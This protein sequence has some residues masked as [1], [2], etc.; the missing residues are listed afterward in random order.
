[1]GYPRDVIESER[2]C[3]CWEIFPEEEA[4]MSGWVVVKCSEDGVSETLVEAAGLEGEG[5]E[6][7]D[8]AAAM[9][10]FLLG[11]LHQLTT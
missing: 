1:M 6:S 10:R 2:D 3:S 5:V 8:M 9:D 11:L 7:N 4:T